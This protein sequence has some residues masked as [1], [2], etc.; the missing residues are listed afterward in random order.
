MFFVVFKFLLRAML[1]SKE[2]TFRS[3]QDNK[4]WIYV[5]QKI[6]SI[7]KRRSKIINS[8]QVFKWTSHWFLL[9]R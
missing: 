7:N 8:G 9:N 1:V 5:L 2:E 6:E 4:K 3:K